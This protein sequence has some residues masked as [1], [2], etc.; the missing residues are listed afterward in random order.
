MP[1]FKTIYTG[2]APVF[3][4]LLDKIQSDYPNMDIITVYG[5]TE[6]EPIAHMRWKDTSDS[7]HSRMLAGD[8]LL[9]GKPVRA[10]QL[11][12]IPDQPTHNTPPTPLPIETIGEIIVTGDHVLKGYLNGRGNDENK[13]NINN[14]IWH[15]TGDAGWLDSSGRVWLVGRCSAAIR[16]PNKPPI[17]PFGIECAAM[18]HPGI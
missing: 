17:Y 1:D 6:A 5:S 14:T 18:S 11:Q 9:V 2:G 12:I 7:D 8:G 10:T 16:R 3:P 4:S 15:R 13:L